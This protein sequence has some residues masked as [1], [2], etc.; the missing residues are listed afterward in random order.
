VL[1]AVATLALMLMMVLSPLAIPVVVTIRH[2][3]SS[4]RARRRDNTG[5]EA[6]AT[7]TPDHRGSPA[8]DRAPSRSNSIP[9]PNKSN[10]NEA[11]P[12]SQRLFRETHPRPIT[13]LAAE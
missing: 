8:A 5:G 11:T 6:S 4:A 2:A 1:S 9:L 10:R 7:R 3:L 13:K 12:L